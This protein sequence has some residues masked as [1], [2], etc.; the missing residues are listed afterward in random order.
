[1]IDWLLSWIPE[2]WRLALAKRLRKSVTDIVIEPYVPSK[3]KYPWIGPKVEWING[4][5][6]IKKDDIYSSRDDDSM[7]NR[8]ISGPGLY[9]NIDT[10]CI[11]EANWNPEPISSEERSANESQKSTI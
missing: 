4:Q 1:M 5:C 8:I 6:V 10:G 3:Q 11:S 9:T 2:E 7:D